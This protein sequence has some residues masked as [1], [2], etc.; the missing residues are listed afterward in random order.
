M[1]RR[2]L[3]MGLELCLGSWLGCVAS[4]CETSCGALR[5]I[6]TH[7]WAWRLFSAADQ[8][9]AS[10][11]P[12]LVDCEPRSTHQTSPKTQRQSRQIKLSALLPESCYDGLCAS[13]SLSLRRRPNA[14]F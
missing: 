7:I 8:G 14:E 2:W 4:S 11:R 12:I 6:W 10:L 13:L 1:S 3:L 5:I 9:I